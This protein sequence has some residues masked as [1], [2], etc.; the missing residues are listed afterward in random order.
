MDESAFK[1]AGED[2]TTLLRASIDPSPVPAPFRLLVIDGPDS[3]QSILLDGSQPSRVLV[4][5][6]AACTIRLSDRT[7]SRRHVAL[8]VAGRQVRVVDLGSTNGT[9]INGIRVNDAVIHGGEIIQVG[10]TSFRL[11]L[12]TQS[13]PVR[14]P[15]A[16]H[17]GR[18][19]GCSTEMRRLYPLC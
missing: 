12:D 3:G 16:S 5:Q 17:F 6:S 15:A 19:I 11:E 10:N 2:V 1:P 18:V 4:G 9:L 14:V 7:V 13:S 8:D